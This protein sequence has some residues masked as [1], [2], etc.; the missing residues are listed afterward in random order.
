MLSCILAMSFA[1]L[2]SLIP[3]T[4]TSNGLNQQ[5]MFEQSSS[6]PP[7]PDE[8]SILNRLFLPQIFKTSIS[9]SEESRSQETMHVA[10]AEAYGDRI[11]PPSANLSTFVSDTG[12]ELNQYLNR[13]QTIDGKLTFTIAITAPVLPKSA[14]NPFGGF[15]DL[16]SAITL[17]NQHVLPKQAML[18]LGI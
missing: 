6:E 9:G 18:V 3:V 4:L 16:T 17:T 11:L 15:L 2:F 7:L 8:P 1:V 10:N 5:A 13:T 14:V 12:G